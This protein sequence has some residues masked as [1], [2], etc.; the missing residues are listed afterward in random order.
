MRVLH[1]RYIP[2]KW[3]PSSATYFSQFMPEMWLMVI[4][5]MTR[6]NI[7]IWR[8]QKQN[9]Y[10]DN[11]EIPHI[12]HL[13]ATQLSKQNQHIVVSEESRFITLTYC[14]WWNSWE[15]TSA[16]CFSCNFLSVSPPGLIH[17]TPFK[18]YWSPPISIYKKLY[19]PSVNTC[20]YRK[21]LT[22]CLFV[23]NSR[24]RRKSIVE[25]RFARFHVWNLN[26][27]YSHCTHLSFS[28]CRYR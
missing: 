13:L 25:K 23:Q 7:V 22:F 21:M 3:L 1:K 5:A 12:L 15:L 17:N 14:I 24:R 10:T 9:K 20:G 4:I 19:T 2:W 8:K 26:F 27:Q 16:S 6:W 28:L 11:P 18:G